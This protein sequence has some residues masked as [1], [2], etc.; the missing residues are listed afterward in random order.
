MFI[1]A[2]RGSAGT[3]GGIAKTLRNG[4]GPVAFVLGSHDVNI[5][6]GVMVANRLYYLSLPVVEISLSLMEKIPGG[7]IIHI[8]EDGSLF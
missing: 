4:S 3:P 1:P 5:S 7:S 8:S 6:V 2:S